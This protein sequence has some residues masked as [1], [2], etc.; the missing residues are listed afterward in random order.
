MKLLTIFALLLVWSAP[1]SAAADISEAE[2]Q[3][4]VAGAQDKATNAFALDFPAVGMIAQPGNYVLTPTKAWLDKAVSAGFDKEPVVFHHATMVAPGSAESKIRSTSGEFPLPNALIIPIPI[5]G[6]AHAG[7]ILLTWWQS[8]SGMQRAI[9]SEGGTEQEPQVYYLD[10]PNTAVSDANKIPETL[11]ADSF[12]VLEEAWA[13]GSAIAVRDKEKGWIYARIITATEDRALV[14]GWGGRLKAVDRNECVALS[15]YPPPMGAN[16]P[17]YIPHEGIMK[18]GRFRQP[19]PAKGRISASLDIA[20][21][22]AQIQVPF[23][24]IILSLPGM[25]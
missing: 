20:G 24:D 13:P 14:I 5:G 6:K 3:P 9:V 22:E 19:D 23:G 15:I 8:G 21:K 10:I 4:P 25:P 11:R 17:I 2:P 7:D 12:K 18:Q 1:F 16:G